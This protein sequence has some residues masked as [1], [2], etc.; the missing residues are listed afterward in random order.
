MMMTWLMTMMES[1]TPPGWDTNPRR[2]APSR[3]WYLFTYPART[4]SW[5]SLSGKEGHT[6][7]QISAEPGSNWEPCGQKAEILQVRQPAITVTA[8]YLWDVAG[9]INIS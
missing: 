9:F 8:Y 1:L 6:N 4:E 3:C 5:V 7:I 2:L